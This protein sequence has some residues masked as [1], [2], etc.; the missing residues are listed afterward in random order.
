MTPEMI[1]L[2]LVDEKIRN[3]GVLRE[4]NGFAA[5]QPMKLEASAP[6]GGEVRLIGLSWHLATHAAHLHMKKQ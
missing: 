1:K 4:M 5:E 3:A 6:T 2:H